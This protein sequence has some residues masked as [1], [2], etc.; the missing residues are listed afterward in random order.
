[1]VAIV[2]IVAM[3]PEDADRMA[4]Y[5][6]FTGRIGE[7]GAGCTTPPQRSSKRFAEAEWRQPQSK[8]ALRWCFG[9]D[10]MET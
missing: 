5:L 6:A 8:R 10:S 3:F 2:T 1:M 4:R 9:G 7:W